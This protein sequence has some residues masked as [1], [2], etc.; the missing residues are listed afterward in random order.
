MA[1]SYSA[2]LNDLSPA[3]ANLNTDADIFNDQYP[4]A[5]AED[6]SWSGFPIYDPAPFPARDTLPT[7]RRN[8]A[9]DDPQPTK[10]RQFEDV[11]NAEADA[12]HALD[13]DDGA[14]FIELEPSVPDPLQRK[15]DVCTKNPFMVT[16]IAHHPKHNHWKET[17]NA[18]SVK[19]VNGLLKFSRNTTGSTANLSSEGRSAKASPAEHEQAVTKIL[20]RLP[21]LPR[22]FGRG[23]HMTIN[24]GALLAFYTTAWCQGRTVMKASNS[25]LKDVTPMCANYPAV[26]HA[27]YALASTYILDYEPSEQVEAMA[28]R[29]YQLSVKSLDQMLLDANNYAPGKEDPLLATIFLLSHGDFINWEYRDKT[30]IP[31]WALALQTAQSVLDKSDPGHRYGTPANVQMTTA[32]RH[33]GG[34][35]EQTSI[36]AADPTSSTYPIAGQHILKEINRFHQWSELSK[37]YRYDTTAE[38]LDSCNLDEDGRVTDAA[39]NTLLGAEAHAASIRIYLHCRFLRKPRQHLDVR[40]ELRTLLRCLDMLPSS[41]DLFTAQSPFFAVCMAGFVAYRPVDREIV[42]QWFLVV[43]DGSRG[44]VPPAWSAIQRLWEWHDK[45][46]VVP[47]AGDQVPIHLRPAWWEDMVEEFVRGEGIL[48]YT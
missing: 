34:W 15:V 42:R 48:T 46:P 29:H 9:V 37:E 1:F 18:Q 3:W 36:F 30:T 47:W 32:R 21:W 23:F 5:L 41:G 10:R 33:I 6:T 40:T 19:E 16:G 25:F 28:E 27:I 22:D 35:I 39:M 8:D 7:K 31:K 45:R 17:A 24:E 20:R 2:F 43:V 38:L 26:R 14:R 12:P 11:L 44:N 4:D 13:L